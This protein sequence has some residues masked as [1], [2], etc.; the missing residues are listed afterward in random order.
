VAPPAALL[1]V[2]GTLGDSNDQ[3]ALCWYRAVRKHD[4]VLPVWRLASRP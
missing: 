4:I 1:D 3:H 2:D